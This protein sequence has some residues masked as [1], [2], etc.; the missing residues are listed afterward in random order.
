MLWCWVVFGM[1]GVRGFA[2]GLPDVERLLEGN[3]IGRTE[4][5]YEEMVRTLVYLAHHP[6][7][8]NR[9]GFDSLKMLFLLSDSQADN[10]L[11]FRERHGCF[12]HAQEL[13]LVRGFGE[14]DLENILPFIVVGDGEREPGERFRRPRQEV[15][16]RVRAR[17]PA[18]EGY[19]R[20][21]PYEFAL[22]KDYEA[23]L[24]NRFH[25]P[26]LGTLVRYGYR[27]GRGWQAGVTLEN[28]A[29]EGYFSRHQRA[30]FDFLSAHVQAEGGG[31]LRRAV[32]GDFRVRWGQGLVAWG[33]FAAGKSDVA[34][35]NEKSGGGIAAYTS[36]DENGYLRGAAVTLA[37]AR[38]VECDLFFSLKRP[39]G[40]LA[41]GDTA[42]VSLYEGGYHRN[43][44]ECAKKRT[45]K[46]RTGGVAVRW[47]TR[48]FRAGVHVLGYGIT[49]RL[50]PGS[51]I[52][53]RYNDS[54]RRRCLVGVD[55][56]TAFRGVYFFGETA[57]SEEGAVATLNGVRTGFSWCSLAF[58]Y[59]RYGKRYASRYASGFGEYAH[60]ANEEG[61]YGG[62]EASPVEN[63]KLSFYADAFRFF[64]PR[65]LATHPG[66]G[67]E[68]LGTLV[69]ARPAAEHTLR[70]KREARPEDLAGGSPAVRRKEE[71]RYQYTRPATGCF[72]WRTRLSVSR[73]AKGEVREC[74]YMLAQD[75][76]YTSQRGRLRM[77]GRVA[78]FDTDSYQSRIYA[79]ENNVLYGYSFPAFY[80][81]GV[82]T[83][84]NL[85]WRPCRGVTCYVK[86]GF[87]FYPG[88]ESA[89]SGVN[90]VEG[91]KQGD[92]TL[93]LRWSF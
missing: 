71:W 62:L 54:G 67:W 27:S 16:A 14:R 9:V 86:S 91:D 17:L 20:Y 47:N 75:V 55:Y 18:S 29:G 21:Y 53:Q 78:W 73:Y 12:T 48:F 7:D 80:G 26:P 24:R 79:Y 72:E 5:G 74:G 42:A 90:R 23:K 35:G 82:R 32:A 70:Y 88:R 45:L 63:L 36:A 89:G 25:G 84:V 58:L 30:G 19:R 76:L 1:S 8:I 60:T 50:L 69:Y 46:E 39:D 44:N 15:L 43:D 66:W 3:D 65:Y 40:T 33:G 13:L 57:W 52:H 37:P 64:A 92:V 41:A 6:L 34:I 51:R 49:P 61:I 85:S 93:Q 2:Q 31:V 11:R 81:R 87:T 22:K 83:Y 4:E 38:Q 77:Q 68:V 56:K 59:R 28:D 10:L